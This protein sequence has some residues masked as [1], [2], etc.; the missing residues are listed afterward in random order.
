MFLL[1]LVL[2]C[3]QPDSGPPEAPARGA[4]SGSEAVDLAAWVKLAEGAW[5]GQADPTPVGA[6]PF[7]LTFAW[8]D[9]ERLSAATSAYGFT[10]A[11]A[12]ERDPELGYGGWR[13][14]EEGSMPGGF[15]QQYT[16]VPAAIEEGR[17]TWERPEDP[18]HL[19]VIEEHSPEAWRMEA[20]VRGE[21][22]AVLDLAAG[23]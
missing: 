4:D 10:L 20:W 14:V 8:E 5:V 17:V 11:F 15:S 22:H 18:E 13:L 1:S 7:G 23:G 12:Y 3:A 6:M 21:L 19:R 16:L 9:E 2:G